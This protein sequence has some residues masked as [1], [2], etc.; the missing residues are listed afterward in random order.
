MVIFVQR[1]RVVFRGYGNRSDGGS[2]VLNPKGKA[3]LRCQ[4]FEE[5]LNVFNLETHQAWAQASVVKG[6]EALRR[7]L[8]LGIQDFCQK[9]GLS[10]LH[11][12]LSGGID[13]A[14]VACLAV[15]A[16]G[17]SRVAGIALP[18]SLPPAG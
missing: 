2:F 8:V 6:A 17:P 5:D 4:Q 9:T 16:L 18:Q 15:D 12:G 10:K 1:G 11:L 3:L 7:A 13:S 14:V